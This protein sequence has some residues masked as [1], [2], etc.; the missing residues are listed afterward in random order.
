MNQQTIERAIQQKSLIKFTYSGHPR[1]V[2]PHVL[3][4]SNGVLQFLGYQIEG[5][6]SSGGA[7]PE[8]RRFDVNRITQ[9]SIVD[10]KFPGRRPFPSGRHS[11]WDQQIL[12]VGM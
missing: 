9:L 8:W 11:S 7:L 1:V 10:Q 12:I 3:G 2:E 6:S 5:S 4:F